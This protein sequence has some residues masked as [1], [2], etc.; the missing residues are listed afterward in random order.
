MSLGRLATLVLFA[1]SCAP[2]LAHSELK[3][4]QSDDSDALDTAWTVIKDLGMSAIECP[5]DCSSFLLSM[6]RC[7]GRI[8]TQISF[9]AGLECIC[10]DV[11]TGLDKCSACTS[12][13]DSTEATSG[14]T[15]LASDWIDSV[16]G[17]IGMERSSSLDASSTSTTAAPETFTAID[18]SN[19]ARTTSFVTNGVPVDNVIPLESR[20][21][22]L[23]VAS[24]SSASLVSLVSAAS[25]SAAA[26]SSSA[27]APSSTTTSAATSQQAASSSVDSVSAALASASAVLASA[28]SAAAAAAAESAKEGDSSG[29]RSGRAQLGS[30]VGAGVLAC[31]ALAVW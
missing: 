11:P 31:G 18:S 14:G 15:A 25:V 6:A 1:A 2:S 5:L 23:S 10:E 3:V 24:A 9:T 13:R 29:A 22:Y 30:L 27:A 20:I 16:C 28:S 17:M 19:E 26:L 4:R 21:S 12:E 8:A 7:S